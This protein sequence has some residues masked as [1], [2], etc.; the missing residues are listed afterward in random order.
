MRVDAARGRAGMAE[1]TESYRNS[2]ER[3]VLAAAIP[4]AARAALLAA[5]IV[6]FVSA[7]APTAARSDVHVFIGAGPLPPLY[8]AYYGPPPWA[9]PVPYP[10]VPAPSVPPPGWAPGHWERHYDAAGRPYD[11]WIPPHLR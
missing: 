2:S 9:Y 4:M 7:V 3:A 1:R 10:W 11:A 8:P 5:P 6:L